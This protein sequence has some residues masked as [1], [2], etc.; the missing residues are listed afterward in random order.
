[1]VLSIDRF[2]DDI[3][4][5]QLWYSRLPVDDP[6]RYAINLLAHHSGYVARC[7][8]MRIWLRTLRRDRDPY[9]YDPW[10]INNWLGTLDEDV[11]RLEHASR[12]LMRIA[13]LHRMIAAGRRQSAYG[14]AITA[15][16]RQ[17]GAASN[18]AMHR[19]EALLRDPATA[20][21]A[22][23]SQA[24]RDAERAR[25]LAAQLQRSRDEA[26]AYIANGRAR[27]AGSVPALELHRRLGRLRIL[28]ALQDKLS[29]L[30]QLLIDRTR[31]L[32]GVEQVVRDAWARI[33]SGAITAEYP[34]FARM[35][36]PDAAAQT[37]HRLR[38]LQ[39]Q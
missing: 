27:L 28:H 37:L 39:P 15:Y 16:L 6:S 25:R 23:L 26:R 32:V 2:I 19:V 11:R 21:P 20:T 7:R 29:S 31:A 22:Q 5:R 12:I 33:T 13:R 36:D 8:G 10:H 14:R 30:G 18:E 3:A 35:A 17:Q 24:L 1:V 34:A 9:S 4:W 38:E